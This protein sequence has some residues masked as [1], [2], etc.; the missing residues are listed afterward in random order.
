MHVLAAEIWHYWVGV[1][2]AGAA[3]LT[4]IAL[5]VAYLATVESKRFPKRR[6]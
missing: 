6:G 2:I 3:I 5:L 1:V 4:V